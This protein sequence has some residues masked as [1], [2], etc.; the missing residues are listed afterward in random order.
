MPPQK[1]EIIN[2]GMQTSQ[3]YS[4]LPQQGV[5]QEPLD[6]FNPLPRLVWLWDITFKESATKETML[7]T[8]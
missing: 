7:L 5:S 6:Q 4:V 3:S 2:P 8:F 1:E